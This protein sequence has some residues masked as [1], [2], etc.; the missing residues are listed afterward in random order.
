MKKKGF[1]LVELLAVIAILAIL[2]IMA[3]P[4]VLRMFNNARRDSF[5][6]EVNTIIRTARQQYLLSGGQ[7]QS[8]SNAEESTNKLDL[9]GNS[10]LKYYVEMNGMG[11]ITKLQVTNGDFKYDKT[12]IID[13]AD[14]SDVEE[15]TEGNE[16]VITPSGDG[17]SSYVY[18]L[19]GIEYASEDEILEEVLSTYGLPVFGRIKSESEQVW[20]IIGVINGV[21][22][23]NSCDEGEDYYFYNESECN[24][25]LQYWEDDGYSYSCQR[26]T[27]NITENQIGFSINNSK[28]YL[29]SFEI[30]DNNTF[31]LDRQ[32]L[33]D[34]FGAS[35]CNGGETYYNCANSTM[36]VHIEGALIEFYTA[37]PYG[38]FNYRCFITN[39]Q[40]LTCHIP[41]G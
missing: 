4:A 5:T 16:L 1:T 40:A 17:N 13:V 31:N 26:G 14:S 39:G 8:W 15:V 23:Y 25:D 19:N 27:I 29:K 28:Y 3:L 22:D 6:N 2:V 37:H 35:S 9:T 18:L 24:D 38:E 7:A 10:N 34:A 12:G 21:E 30:G 41:A 32:I 36:S 11:K 20:C 33:L